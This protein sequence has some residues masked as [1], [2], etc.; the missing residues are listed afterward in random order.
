M[1]NNQ[2]HVLYRFFDAHGNLLYVGLTVNPG[3]RWTSHS[4]DKVWWVDLAMVTVQHF[5]DF[6]SVR[7][8]EIAAI[9]H[10]NPRYNIAGRTP[11]RR[12]SITSVS[13]TPSPPRRATARKLDLI[14][15]HHGEFC[16]HQELPAGTSTAPL[17]EKTIVPKDVRTRGVMLPLDSYSLFRSKHSDGWTVLLWTGPG[18][19]DG[20]TYFYYYRP[21]LEIP[22]SDERAVELLAQ[23]AEPTNR[24]PIQGTGRPRPKGLR[25]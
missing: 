13:T 8:A 12:G 2:P 7:A 24:R 4:K 15:Q 3:T 18:W 20:N 17:D 21:Y 5:P 23:G 25:E 1:T 22:I 16:L 9:R 10:E 6:A 11:G 14:Y 19:A